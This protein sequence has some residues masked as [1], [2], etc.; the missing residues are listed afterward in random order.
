MRIAFV[1]EGRPVPQGSM[2]AAYNRKDKV[3]RVHHGQGAALALWRSMVRQG[4]REA[5]ATMSLLPIRISIQFGMPR[6]KDQTRLSG[7]RYVPKEKY[8]YARPAHVPDIDKLLRAVAD[9]LTKVCYDDDRQLVEVMLSKVYGDSTYIEITDEG[10]S[11]QQE[12]FST[13]PTGLGFAQEAHTK[14]G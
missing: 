14:T 3:S 1:V 6:P 10:L 11:P 5:G 8:Q 4:A 7:G 2:V 12:A 13:L 9:A